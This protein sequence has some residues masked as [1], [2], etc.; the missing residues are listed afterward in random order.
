MRQA[1]QSRVPA[2]R[3]KASKPLKNPV[4]VAVAGETPSLTGEFVGETYR[5]LEHTQIHPPG[6]QHQ[7]GPIYLWVTEEETESALRAEQVALFPLGPFP[8][9]QHNNAVMWVALP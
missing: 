7:K 1:G 8:H 9:I 3:N 5:V 2:W 4:R 6:I